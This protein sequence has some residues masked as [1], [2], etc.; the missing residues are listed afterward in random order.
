MLTPKKTRS[1]PSSLETI[2]APSTS[3]AA[4][5]PPPSAAEAQSNFAQ[6]LAEVPEFASYGPVYNS[7]LKPVQLTE[8]ETE[9]QVSCTKHIFR[10]HIVFQVRSGAF[11]LSLWQMFTQSSSQSSTF[12]TRFPT[13]FWN[14]SLLLCNLKLIQDWKK[15][16]SCQ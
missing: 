2:G 6:Q 13:L 8:K 3:K 7:S 16:L 5:P 9:Y 11:H 12:P 10:E 1:G 14:N 4:T 15:T